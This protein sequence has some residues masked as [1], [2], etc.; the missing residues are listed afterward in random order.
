VSLIDEALKR[1]DAARRDVAG[2][3]SARPWVP[4]PLPDSRRVRRRRMKWVL[5]ATVLF[6]TLVTAAFF[7][8][9]VP[10]RSRG[11]VGSAS[12]GTA[13]LSQ[14]AAPEIARA[15]PSPAIDSEVFV[16]PPPRGLGP[17]S[18]GHAAS[19]ATRKSVSVESSPDAGALSSPDMV[20]R[21]PPDVGPAPAI[22]RVKSYPG[23]VRLPGGERIELGGIVYSDTHPVALINGKVVEVGAVVE[24]FT[25]TEIQTDRVRLEGK[26]GTTWI[27]VK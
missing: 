20:V 15:S 7:F 10:G 26:G 22:S 27:R 17:S 23:E 9:R 8:G 11:Q 3:P 4:T 2:S 5:S 14:R 25:V 13:P 18:R 16:A 24:G 12:A 1:A 6:G 21:P 19:P